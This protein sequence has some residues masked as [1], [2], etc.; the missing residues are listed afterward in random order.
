LANQIKFLWKWEQ[1]S[2][3][4]GISTELAHILIMNYEL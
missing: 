1:Y 3:L 2:F 4:A